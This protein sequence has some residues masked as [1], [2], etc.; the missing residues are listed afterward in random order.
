MK[1]FGNKLMKLLDND[2]NDLLL[3]QMEGYRWR[4]GFSYEKLC[5]IYK[6]VHTVK[7]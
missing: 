6:E 5:K 1:A 4:T 7:S 2:E 3:I